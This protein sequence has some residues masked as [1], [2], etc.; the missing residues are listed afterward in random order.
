[1]GH[2]L[3]ARSRRS[4]L[5]AAAALAL[6]AVPAGALTIAATFASSITSDPNAAV[7]ESTINSAIAQYQSTFSDPITV[8]ITYQ[9]MGSGLG[10]SST[11]IY[12]IPYASVYA[13]LVS[14][15][16]S[17]SDAVALASLPNQANSPV[18]NQANMWVTS[19]NGRALGFSTP[20]SPDGIISINT[21]ITNDDRTSIDPTK[22]DLKAVV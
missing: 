18:D 5:L 2:Q 14:H 22:Y 10:Q 1:M 15:A 19:A 16:T 8:N 4:V 12:S 13:A 21:S 11:S 17:A 3:S 9:E 6:P 20:A 7:I